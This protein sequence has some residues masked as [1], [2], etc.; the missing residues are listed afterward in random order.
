MTEKY[1]HTNPTSKRN[2]VKISTNQITW[3]VEICLGDRRT[4]QGALALKFLL[5]TNN[6]LGFFSP[7]SSKKFRFHLCH[8]MTASL[9]HLRQS[10]DFPFWNTP[11][12]QWHFTWCINERLSTWLVSKPKPLWLLT[13]NTLQVPKGESWSWCLGLYRAC[14]WMAS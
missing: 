8:V 1:D 12:Q 9:C 6:K 14:G 11:E 7:H 4:L 3:L 5:T 13:F 10:L 2:K